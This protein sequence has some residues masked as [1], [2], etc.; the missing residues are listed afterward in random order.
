MGSVVLYGVPIWADAAIASRRI[1]VL[2]RRAQRIIALRAARA[3]R[4]ATVTV[5]ALVP[6]LEL[7]GQTHS[8]LYR[9]VKALREEGILLTAGVRTVL[10]WQARHFL[11]IRW[12]RYLSESDAREQRAVRANLPLLPEWLGRSWGGVTYRMAQVLTKAWLLW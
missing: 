9:R 7:M 12:Q 5:L 6:P 4:T 2:M 3:Y 10:R 1:K 11:V 8:E